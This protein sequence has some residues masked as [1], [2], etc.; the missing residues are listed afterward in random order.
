MQRLALAA[1]HMHITTG[2]HGQLPHGGKIAV[3]IIVVGIVTA[4][5]VG[6][7]DPESIFKPVAQLFA[8]LVVYVQLL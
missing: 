2:D 7:A 4:E 3:V 1:V 6:N 8:A 5:E